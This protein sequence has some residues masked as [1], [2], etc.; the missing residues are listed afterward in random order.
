MSIYKKILEKI[1]KS[2]LPMT[3]FGIKNKFYANLHLSAALS[4]WK[5]GT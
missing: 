1:S 5:V 4:P 2:Y 3:V